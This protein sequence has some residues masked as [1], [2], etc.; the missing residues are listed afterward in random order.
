MDDYYTLQEAADL[1][2]LS[3]HALYQRIE[4]GQIRSEK[5]GGGRFIHKD[6]IL[7]F[8]KTQEKGRGE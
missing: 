8:K 7:Q 1:L 4:R 2:G 6:E 3:Y 5:K